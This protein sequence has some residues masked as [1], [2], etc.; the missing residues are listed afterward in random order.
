MPKVVYCDY[1]RLKTLSS[2]SLNRLAA[3]LSGRMRVTAFVSFRRGERRALGCVCREEGCG[4]CAEGWGS[5][6]RSAEVSAVRSPPRA[7]SRLGGLT[8]VVSFLMLI[9]LDAQ[10]PLV[11]GLLPSVSHVRPR[12]RQRHL[13]HQHLIMELSR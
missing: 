8:R 2:G 10:G 13:F 6:T 12:P 4:F 1:S 7:P 3:S 11:A 5:T 9:S